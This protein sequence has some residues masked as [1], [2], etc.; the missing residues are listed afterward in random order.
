M[1]KLS[2]TNRSGG[3]LADGR[4][5]SCC[6]LTGRGARTESRCGSA[7]KRGCPRSD[8][9]T[10]GRRVPQLVNWIGNVIA[11]VGAGLALAGGL[12]SYVAGRGVGDTSSRQS[13][14]WPFRGSRACLSSGSRKEVAVSHKPL[15][16]YPPAG[17]A[18]DAREPAIRSS[19]EEPMPTLIYDIMRVMFALTGPAA[20]IC[21]VNAGTPYERRVERCSG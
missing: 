4:P 3:D 21:L 7:G 15:A 11:P 1:L 18:F 12:I 20:F 19:H 9:C 5:L 13:D 17:G 6:R 14:V 10:A 16:L 2:G 8:G